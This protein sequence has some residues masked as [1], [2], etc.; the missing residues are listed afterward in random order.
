M[1]TAAATATGIRIGTAALLLGGGQARL[2]HRFVVAGTGPDIPDG[3]VGDGVELLH[4]AE[5]FSVEHILL[6]GL[7]RK[8]KL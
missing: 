5:Q 6:E 7:R 1:I 2:V 4:G 3:A 8:A